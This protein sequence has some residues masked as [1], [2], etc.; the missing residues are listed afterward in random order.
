MPTRRETIR[1]FVPGSPL[2]RHLGIRLDELSADR[3]VLVLP[4]DGRLA[5][6]GDVV[7]GGAVASLLDT[8]GMAAAWSDDEEP[9]SL[10]GATVSMN[11]DF[12]AAARGQDLRAE[13]SVVKRGRTLCFVDIDVTEPDGRLVARGSLVYRFG[14]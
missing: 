8:A 4:F 12:V 6:M 10:S 9:E 2:V 14:G 7:H 1:E 13:A 3:A 5:T 11:V